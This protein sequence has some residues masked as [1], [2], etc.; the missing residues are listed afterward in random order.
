MKVSQS[1]HIYGLTFEEL[2]A[3]IVAHGMEGFRAKQIWRAIY[4]RTIQDAQD[5]HELPLGSRKDLDDLLFFNSLTPNSILQSEDQLTEKILFSLQDMAAIETVLMAYEGRQ[6]TCISSQ[7]GCGLGCVFCAS[8][9]MGFS[10]NLTCGEIVEQVIFSD[11]TFRDRGS[12]LTNVVV[13]GMGEPFQNYDAVLGAIDILNNPEGFN[14]GARRFTISTV[15]LVPGIERFTREK[16]QIN[17][18]ISLHA[19]TDELRNRLLPINKQ[20]PL[21]RLLRTCRAYVDKTHRRITFEWALIRGVNDSSEQ[22]HALVNLLKGMR[23]HINLIP[24]N[25]TKAYQGEPS[26]TGQIDDFSSILTTA[27]LNVTVR[28]RRGID[29]QAGCGQLAVENESTSST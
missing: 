20:Y 1:P 25:D 17:L 13:M 2:Q 6:T 28:T 29:I 3:I 27:G 21:D 16:R 9:Q 18:A 5:L 4:T 8:G 12:K 23:C 14:F 26:S 11:R 22:A 15:G 24:L 10:R 19:A 7:S